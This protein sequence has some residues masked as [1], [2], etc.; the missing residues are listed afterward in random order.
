L[1]DAANVPALIARFDDPDGRVGDAAADTVAKTGKQA[2]PALISALKA[3]PGSSKVYYASK[4][5]Q[6]VGHDAV[7]PLV[8]ALRSPDPVVAQWSAKLLGDLGDSA[9]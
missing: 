8:A 2:V 9:A 4:S 3:G 7:P 1:P 5:L 6:F